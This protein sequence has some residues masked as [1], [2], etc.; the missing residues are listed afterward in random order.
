M[1]FPLTS[2]HRKS[3]SPI[4]LLGLSILSQLAR[5]DLVYFANSEYNAGEFGPGPNQSF[6]T[7]NYTPTQST[8]SSGYLFTAPRGFD[9]AQPGPLIYDNDGHLV[10]KTYLGEPHILTWSGTILGTG[11]G[12]G[13]ILMFNSQYQR[14]ARYTTNLTGVTGATLADFHET[15][16]TPNNSAVMTAY[17]I[18]EMNLTAYGGPSTGYIL[19]SV[20]QEIN[21]TSGETLFTWYASE[22]VSP[23]ECHNPLGSGGNTTGS[24]WDYFHINSI[25][26]DDDGNWLISSRYCFALYYIDGNTGDIIWRMGGTNSSF[27][28]GPGA[29]YRYQH[30]A[31]WLTKNDTYATI[32]WVFSS[33][34]FVEL[35]WIL[36]R[37]FDD[38][39]VANVPASRGLYLGI[40]FTN[41]SVDLIQDFIPFNTTVSQS[42]G[43]VQL[44]PNGNFLVG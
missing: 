4:L 31:R 11:I 29:D 15:R 21:I 30:H 34:V 19:D 1:W 8:I 25:D 6:V 26:F 9:T 12:S 17:H 44:Q 22:N 38:F 27:A 7:A 40:N 28:M 39:G 43:S 42:Q 13:Y 3:S 41:M 2:L 18:S 37:V 24:A 36:Y 16:I 35:Q 32:T 20:F 5:S 10:W 23:S 14:V 33:S